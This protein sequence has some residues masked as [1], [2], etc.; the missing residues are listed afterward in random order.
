MIDHF[1]DFWPEGC[2]ICLL[3][4]LTSWLQLQFEHVRESIPRSSPAPVE[5]EDRGQPVRNSI[6]SEYILDLLHVDAGVPALVF[7]YGC[8]SVQIGGCQLGS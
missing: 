2:Q 1:L 5:S 7:A 3:L 4:S 8:I 6:P